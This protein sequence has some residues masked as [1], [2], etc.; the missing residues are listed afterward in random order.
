MSDNLASNDA[1]QLITFCVLLCHIFSALFN[2]LLFARQSNV[3]FNPAL[4][5][6]VDSILQKG[7]LEYIARGNFFWFCNLHPG[8]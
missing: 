4:A 1:Y 8:I 6:L 2:N 5:A 3:Q 7:L